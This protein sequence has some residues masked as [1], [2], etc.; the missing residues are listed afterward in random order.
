MALSPPI[1][2]ANEGGLRRRAWW[3]AVA[4]VLA[5]V[6]LVW[7]IPGAAQGV[8]PGE[9][10]ARLAAATTIFLG[11]FLEA[12]PFLLLGV[13]VSAAIH[14]WVSP[15]SIRRL[16][17]R[18]PLPAALAGVL[19][20]L[21]ILPVCECGTVPA[22]RR[23]L[24]KGAPLPFGV[25]YLLAAPAINPVAI[26]ST[27]IAFNGNPLFVGGRVALTLLV[28]LIVAL[29][30]GTDAPERVLLPAAPGD[31]HDHEHDH[32][33]RGARRLL[34]LAR[35]AN[36]EFFEM[37]RYLIAGA[38]LAALLQA[39]IP[40]EALLA[41]GQGPIWSVAAL[42]ALAVILS[43]CSTVD[44][45]V[46]LGFAFAFSPGAVLAFLVFG[47]MIDLK[48]ILLFG[49]IF[50][51]RAVVALVGLTAIWVAAGAL[52]VNLFAGG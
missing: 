52:A 38:G 48:S 41:L 1:G 33:G 2:G 18:A 44:A 28:A 17:P 47:P 51:R 24:A 35:H 27:W 43:I 20:G 10:P 9:L 5:L 23:L 45:F 12:I 7:R 11:I 13:L 29:L 39:F 16:I 50:R 31:H 42:M 14:L 15:E 37:A 21:T 46:A 3:V 4:G 8:V 22:T 49:T 36:D 30:L 34:A 25:A 26:A 32:G 40:R 6:A 19:C